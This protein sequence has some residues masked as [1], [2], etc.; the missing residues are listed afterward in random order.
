M[1][2]SLNMICNI[3]DISNFFV[4]EHKNNKSSKLTIYLSLK[5]LMLR[6]LNKK[7]T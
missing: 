1:I 6:Y 2:S 7:Q 4:K 3:E 5:L